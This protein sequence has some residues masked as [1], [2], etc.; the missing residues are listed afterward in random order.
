MR[1][2]IG[3]FELAPRRGRDDGDRL[4]Q[5][6]TAPQADQ[7]RIAKGRTA[8][9]NLGISSDRTGDQCRGLRHGMC[10]DACTSSHPG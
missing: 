6:G 9:M 7:S 10:R 5:R 8:A 4:A 2:E 1:V 3:G